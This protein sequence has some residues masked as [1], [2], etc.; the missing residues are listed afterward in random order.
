MADVQRTVS[1][2][3]KLDG[4]GEYKA[5]LQSINS[6]TSALRAGVKLLDEQY[7]GQANSMAALT[8]RQ[9]N[10]NS[11]L[12]LAKQKNALVEAQLNKA[13]AAVTKYGDEIAALKAKIAT[14]GDAEGKLAKQLETSS[15]NFQKAQ[16]SAESH[17]K[18]AVKSA[19]E[20]A[21]L[22]NAIKDNSKYLSEAEKSATKT[23]SSIDQFGKQVAA[24]KEPVEDLGESGS[25]AFE[26]L[27]SALMSAGL[28]RG[29][30]ELVGLFVQASQASIEFES[31]FTGVRKTVTGTPEEL[32][33]ISDEIKRMSTTIPLSTTEIS[34]IAEIAGQ[35]GVTA[36]NIGSATEVAAALGVT[37]NMSSE[38]AITALS[39]LAIVTGMSTSQF[40]NLGSSIVAVGNQSNATESE[41]ADMAMYLAAAAH[42][43]GMTQ[44][45]IIGLSG[46][47]SSVG[48]ES[49][50]GGT[51]ISRTLVEMSLAAQTGGD[52]LKKFADVAG[53]SS[54]AFASLF[55]ASAIDGLNAFI[56]G[57]STGGESAIKVLNDMGITEI[58]QRD[59]ILRLANASGMLASYVDMS[60][61]AFA[62]NTALSEKA[63]QRYGTT[64]SKV[65]LLKNAVNLLAITVGDQYNPSVV[66]ATTTLT[67]WVQSI[68]GFLDRNPEAVA[69]IT[70]LAAALSV[71][72]IAVAGG[73]VA[74]NI[75]IPA[76]IKFN[77]ALAAN[78]IGVVV[79]A[80][81]ALT[82]G[83]A[84]ATAAM[85]FGTQKYDEQIQK[86]Q[87]LREEL[88]QSSAA[89]DRKVETITAEGQAVSGLIDQLDSLLKAQ[90]STRDSS[91]QIE[92]VVAQLNAAVS[93]LDLKY[94]AMT[95]TINTTTEAMRA[96]TDAMF[97]QA[98]QAA[99]VDRQVQ[100]YI[101]WQDSQNALTKTQEALTSARADLAAQSAGLTDV[102]GNTMDVLTPKA[103]A[104]K[105][106]VRKLTTEEEIQQETV[107]NL[108]DNY[109]ALS[110]SMTG[111]G[112]TAEDSSDAI[113]NQTD[114]LND[115]SASAQ[116]LVDKYKAIQ[117]SVTDAAEKV[118]QFGEKLDGS[119]KKSI[120]YY[121]KNEKSKEDFW[122]DY[123]ANLEKAKEKGVDSSI[124]AEL[125]IASEE[126]AQKLA[127]VVKG[128]AEEI[129]KLNQQVKDGVEARQ[130][131]IDQATAVQ[132][133]AAGLVDQFMTD[134]QAFIAEMNQGDA[135]YAAGSSTLQ[136]L[137]DGIN[138]QMP[139]FNSL[140]SQ[141]VSAMNKISGL[142]VTLPG[143]P[144]YDILGHPL[145]GHKG[146]LPYVPYDDYVFRAHEGE[147][148]LTKGEANL[149]RA[150]KNTLSPA[151]EPTSEQMTAVPI[152]VTASTMRSAVGSIAESTKRGGDYIDQSTLVVNAPR[153][154]TPYE[155]A[156]EKRRQ[157]RRTRRNL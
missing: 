54:D 135:A 85:D 156:A 48:L 148:V 28:I 153:Q 57:L 36:G 37:T 128:S 110:S 150:V 107:T 139:G 2:L 23:A 16:N 99:M 11:Q 26:A 146:G 55:N 117:T 66:N 92:N 49:Q 93:G 126:H 67:G 120:G 106:E 5:A 137:V 68:D 62:E 140:I 132:G 134:M 53:M 90:G 82:A 43:V 98:L 58:R 13:K 113:D 45:Q 116:T 73:T 154:L 96:M 86:N 152:P 102:Y 69:G 44:A 127:A 38:Q 125:S 141:I 10:L 22:N 52:G 75:I 143:A 104:L 76:V 138:A 30:E 35:L 114:S 131:Y 81:A 7:K 72:A 8:A 100:A 18:A 41:I 129:D 47:L 149:W 94:N 136:S 133:E 20:V 14:E 145:K 9:A 87:Q 51:A 3:L 155:I 91:A 103:I 6:Q 83:I 119:A 147:A 122:K 4:E 34:K 33:A 84:A 144:K 63:E 15:L 71:L 142:S 56:T 46:A 80:L 42:Q 70:G 105:E 1:T 29:M 77:A 50:A 12:D 59:A 74:V 118:G 25:A 115:A 21:K 95:G 24:A 17:T 109:D 97:D 151:N 111:V 61:T 31:A 78:P 124:I 60:S 123:E 27:G 101:E 121:T 89:Y 130:S 39:K 40:S 19:V 79:I 157:N 88:K 112:D 108:K 65:Q 32:A 64:E